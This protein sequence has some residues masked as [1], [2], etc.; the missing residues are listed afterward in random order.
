MFY[1]VSVNDEIH[2]VR[3]NGSNIEFYTAYASR[4]GTLVLVLNAVGK[5]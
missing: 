1:V 5:V 2:L 4:S 3:K